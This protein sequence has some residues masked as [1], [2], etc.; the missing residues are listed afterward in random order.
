MGASIRMYCPMRSDFKYKTSWLTDTVVFVDSLEK[1]DVLGLFRPS[2]IIHP[3][4]Y[5]SIFIERIENTLSKWQKDL[6]YETDLEDTVL[7]IKALILGIPVIG[8]GGGG[9]LIA[10][11]NGCKMIQEINGHHKLHTVYSYNKESN[12]IY[13][14]HSQLMYPFDLPKEDYNL[15]AWTNKLSSEYIM[16]KFKQTTSIA[17]SFVPVEPE[18]IYFPKTNSL[19]IQTGPESHNDSNYVMLMY[20]DYL[21]DLFNLLIFDKLTTSLKKYEST[22]EMIERLKKY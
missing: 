3:K 17:K 19:A 1:A 21:I 11:L 14:S 5:Q 16:D 2:P 6:L 8:T 10:A 22:E 20:E 12:N 15:V 7:Y 18:I 9:M 13:S 4:V